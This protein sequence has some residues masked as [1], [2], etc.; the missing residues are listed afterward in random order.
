[1]TDLPIDDKD[2]PVPNETP[3][4]KPDTPAP[5]TPK[6]LDGE[7]DGAPVKVIEVAQVSATVVRVE[8][9]ENPGTLNPFA[10][11]SAQAIAPGTVDPQ[12]T[13]DVPDDK[14][15]GESGTETGATADG[16]D[17]KPPDTEGQFDKQNAANDKQKLEYLEKQSKDKDKAQR[18]YQNLNFTPIDRDYLGHTIMV[19]VP[20]EGFEAFQRSTSEDERREQNIFI[21]AGEGNSGRFTVAL[22]LAL[23]LSL[24]AKAV[25]PNIYEYMLDANTSTL[26]LQN[27]VNKIAQGNP[28]DEVDKNVR[29]EIPPG[30][31]V[32][33]RDLLDKE[34]VKRE[35]SISNA[36]RYK[37]TLD[38]CKIRLIL[39]TQEKEA[40]HPE[41]KRFLSYTT[42]K[43]TGEL[44]VDLD[45]VYARHLD[46][47][48][49]SEALFAEEPRAFLISAKNE[50]GIL[51]ELQRPTEINSFLQ[52]AYN[53]PPASPQDAVEMAKKLVE[54][55]DRRQQTRAWFTRLEFNDKLYA[56]LVVLFRGI[57]RYQLDEIYDG[58][59]LILREELKDMLADPRF[60]SVEITLKNL[61]LQ[62]QR[63]VLEFPKKRQRDYEIEI[64]SQIENYYRLLW[65][66]VKP[67]R[68]IIQESREEDWQL[69][70]LLATAIGQIG[71]FRKN[72][73]PN[74][75]T[76]LASQS[77][78]FIALSSTDVLRY[79]A[80]DINHHPFVIAMLEL[81]SHSKD[82]DLTWVSS[83]A[84]ASVYE[85]INH[86]LN[87]N[88]YAP[89]GRE[90][91]VLND[92]DIA[93]KTLETLRELLE[94]LCKAVKEI[95]SKAQDEQLE[96]LSRVALAQAL[97]TFENDDSDFIAAM[98]KERVEWLN[99]QIAINRIAMSDDLVIA[100]VRSL[101]TIS[102][103]SPADMV[104]L[105]KKWMTQDTLS[106]QW[107]I[108]RMAA[109]QL[110]HAT[111]DSKLR[112]V[113]DWLP[114]LDMLPEMLQASRDSQSDI[115]ERLTTLVVSEEMGKRGL[116]LSRNRVTEL[117]AQ[118][119]IQT[120][121]QSLNVWYGYLIENKEAGVTLGKGERNLWRDNVYPTLLV[122]VNGASQSCRAL[123]KDALIEFWL[124]SDHIE[125]R[126]SAMALLTRAYVLD[127]VVL[128]VPVSRFGVILIDA[129]DMGTD[130]S[131]TEAAFTISQRLT[132]LAPLHVYRLGWTGLTDGRKHDPI[133]LG[134]FRP[135]DAEAG[136]VNTKA[137][138][139]YGASR[140]PLMMPLLEPY[141][142]GVAPIDPSNCHF[143]LI[144]NTK[145]IWDWG[146]ILHDAQEFY[147]PTT[148]EADDSWNVFRKARAQTMP[149]ERTAKRWHWHGKFIVSD[150][151][152]WKLPDG[153][154]PETIL[155][156]DTSAGFGKILDA[157]ESKLQQQIVLRLHTLE[158]ADWLADLTR[159][160][161]FQEDTPLDLADLSPA[162]E[163]W[164]SEMDKVTETIPP[165]DVTLIIAW[166]V[167]LVSRHDLPAAVARVLAWLKS[168]DPKAQLMGRA[169]TKQ[170]FYFYGVTGYQARVDD[171]AILLQLLTPFMALKP[172]F[173]EFGRLLMIVFEWAKSE[174]W[175]QRLLNGSES[176]S[177]LLTAITGV[178]SRADRNEIIAFLDFHEAR[179]RI[180]DLFIQ[181][182]LPLGEFTGL[183]IALIDWVNDERAR[184]KALA[185]ATES[186]RAGRR[187]QAAPRIR[188]QAPLPQRTSEA[189]A[190]QLLE[191]PGLSDSDQ[192]RILIEISRNEQ[193]L[194]HD[195][196][197]R[198]AFPTELRSLKAIMDAV[199]LQVFNKDLPLPPLPEG[200]RYGLILVDG[201]I[202]PGDANRKAIQ[203]LSDATL[204]FLKALHDRPDA[205]IVPVV[206]RLGRQDFFYTYPKEHPKKITLK[207]ADVLPD[208]LPRFAPLIG[209]IF[210]RY[211]GEQI[212][213]ALIMTITGR[214]TEVPNIPDLADWVDL[215]DWR[216]R[217]FGYKLN[218]RANLPELQTLSL[219]T[220]IKAN[221]TE[222]LNKTFRSVSQ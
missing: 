194:L 74:E 17:G 167:L 37:R 65:S 63:E 207:D 95:D 84:I 54:R 90:S 151:G 42:T 77:Q 132:T 176:G 220:D 203:S 221:L 33:I 201:S 8:I 116:G 112:V 94:N 211:P 66:L 69:R 7:P 192:R 197:V 89:R 205:K 108:G 169:C 129:G 91:E 23:H 107:I 79:L 180:T 140:P 115:L 177:E 4:E 214:P 121:I 173:A 210:D 155:I 185:E 144:L 148:P 119:P 158:Q 83:A 164:L 179:L 30:S 29:R 12:A 56:M 49:D 184:L 135:D 70:R 213:F 32:I 123:L 206:H 188:P 31:V 26:S 202:L 118:T 41:F 125:V 183:I 130:P 136:T 181:L 113:E 53:N 157:I 159:Y 101:E 86:A 13:V 59:V 50:R 1:M 209:P 35:L 55:Y 165:R 60:G 36:A 102:Q 103:S 38:N 19:F 98:E 161:Q 189:T 39:T 76:E 216:G 156:Y 218:P 219:G 191:L 85:T 15:T 195:K 147:N 137:L 81:W 46:R 93:R 200:H 16:G 5:E 24:S 171:H 27:I 143:V 78:A 106:P 153:L 72:R 110:F 14:A 168:D 9:P 222:I 122:T 166:T 186:K 57:K 120:A 172:D 92:A 145:E 3:D 193:A 187:G 182:R 104:T 160:V 199:R 45:V 114:L 190:Q 141:E 87:S 134:E 22:Q 105:L 128:D 64:R 162:F 82:Y 99:R 150:R 175:S 100:L 124:D 10:P 127:G 96:Q 196:A 61:D 139:L 51:A 117:I 109:N 97:A 217:I 71:A 34:S 28:V 25:S 138:V 152:G 215:P 204:N 178:E 208:N 133:L 170:L 163:R 43:P 21:I 58:M 73:L 48:F 212:A 154:P 40:D 18:E 149:V 75:L 68:L 67:L 131:Y 88:R 142:S 6:P 44:K 146:E 47:Y 111:S 80:Q 20:P 52:D 198:A 11:Q 174:A 62:E 126:R 2:N